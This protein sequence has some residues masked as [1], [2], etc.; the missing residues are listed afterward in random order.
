[1]LDVST[2]DL[3]NRLSGIRKCCSGTSPDVHRSLRRSFAQSGALER[4][5]KSPISSLHFITLP[6]FRPAKPQGD[7]TQGKSN[8]QPDPGED[9]RPLERAQTREREETP[10]RLFVEV[11]HP[12]IPLVI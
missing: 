11:Q 12:K 1:L 2:G 3:L 9:R 8:R 7:D 6:E 10:L 5:T 4:S